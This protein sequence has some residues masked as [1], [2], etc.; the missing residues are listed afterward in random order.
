MTYV[1]AYFRSRDLTPAYQEL[2]RARIEKFTKWLGCDPHVS[3]LNCDDVN[4]FL[5]AMIEAGAKPY[6]VDNYRRV[7]R[8]VWAAAYVDGL[9]N[10]PPLRLKKI[11]VPRQAIQAFKHD[12]IRRLLQHVA[13]FADYFPN[14]VCR[15]DFWEAAINGAYSTGLRR[16]DLLRVN[17]NLID[18]E[19]LVTVVM[20]KT[21]YP[22]TVRFNEAAMA[23]IMR[24]AS[25]KDERAIRW[26]Y[27]SNAMPRQFRA[28]VKAAG[29]RRGQFKW[30]RRA[31]GSYAEQ[32][33]PG[34]GSRMLG[35]RTDAVFR[36]H[37]EDHS[38]TRRDPVSP[39]PIC[40]S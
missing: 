1:A 31:A 6:T 10:E 30:L 38:I 7:I 23:A 13:T 29:V 17:R 15:R 37:Y 40:N 5:G 35:H 26:P 25:A 14:G 3:K 33:Q 24:M 36:A 39:P 16:S 18:R 9:A 12:E 2:T 28:I 4:E 21:G 32:A 19:G 8:C 27:H 20:S 11:R 34:G 22:I